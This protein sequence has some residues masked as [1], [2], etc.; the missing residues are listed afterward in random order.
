MQPFLEREYKLWGLAHKV[1][2]DSSKAL[3][4]LE[5]ILNLANSAAPVK[6]T[7]NQFR[8]LMLGYP[9]LLM[10]QDG[11]PDPRGEALLSAPDAPDPDDVNPAQQDVV[12]L[13]QRLVADNQGRLN[14]LPAL[15]PELWAIMNP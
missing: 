1:P 8:E 10:K 14:Q 9:G 11:T 4:D 12:G 2:F 5:R 3:A 15:Y 6:I 13:Y 7:V